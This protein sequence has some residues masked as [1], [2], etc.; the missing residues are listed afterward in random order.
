MNKA[1]ISNI[2]YNGLTILLVPLIIYLLYLIIF[3]DDK[4]IV[5]CG[6]SCRGECKMSKHAKQM[7]DLN[8]IFLKMEGCGHCTRLKELLDKNNLTN[9]VKIVDS[10]SPQVDTLKNKY[11]EINGFPTLISETTGKKMVGGRSNIEDVLAALS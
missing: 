1:E 5:G 6:S 9:Q 2:F 11:G 4:R 8:I 7:R 3:A 10:N